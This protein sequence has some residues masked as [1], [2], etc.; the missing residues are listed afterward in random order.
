[1]KYM[2]IDFGQECK[3]IE[4]AFLSNWNHVEVGRG[5]PG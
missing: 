4:N 5:R 3:N 2:D 1:M